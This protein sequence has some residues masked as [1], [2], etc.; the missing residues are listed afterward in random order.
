MDF[1]D[2]I[3][4][5]FSYIIVMHLFFDCF[6]QSLGPNWRPLT[7]FLKKSIFYICY[8]FR[9]KVKVNLDLSPFLALLFFTFFRNLL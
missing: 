6:A 8:P 4:K 5:L 3:L 2:F 7:F 1:L 9:T